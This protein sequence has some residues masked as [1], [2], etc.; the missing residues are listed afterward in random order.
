[1]NQS[2]YIAEMVARI[3][4]GNFTMS[5]SALKAFEVSPRSFLQYKQGER[6]ETRA[7]RGGSFNH[8]LLLEPDKVA[9]VFIEAPNV[10]GATIEGKQA[11]AELFEKHVGQAHEGKAKIDDLRKLIEAATGK[12][13]IEGREVEARRKQF[14]AVNTDE[15]AR[16]VIYATTSTEVEAEWHFEGLNFRGRIDMMGEGFLA[17]FK[18]VADANREKVLRDLRIWKSQAD[19]GHSIFPA[20]I[21]QAFH[22]MT[23]TGAETYWLIFAD[24]K[25]EVC[26]VN[27]SHQT[28]EA[29]GERLRWLCSRFLD[30]VNVARFDPLV[31]TKSQA[32]WAGDGFFQI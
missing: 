5:H 32:F 29:A 28:A 7:M 3:D 11:W 14:E 31:F 10:N 12:S 16:A 17:D 8:A 21:M 20:E 9:E 4:S 18:T 24:A 6:T 13:V 15:A 25:G 22:Y 27:V 30:C 1:M 2:D 19:F 26:V 23:A